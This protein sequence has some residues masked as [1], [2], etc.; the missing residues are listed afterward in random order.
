MRNKN[1]ICILLSCTLLLLCCQ[2]NNNNK[3]TLR[4]IKQ[5]LKVHDDNINGILLRTQNITL[6][7]NANF[8]Y[9]NYGLLDSMDVYNDTIASSTL[10]KSLKLQYLPNKIRAFVYDTSGR[11]ILDLYYDADRKIVKMVDTTLGNFGFFF[12]YN[13]NKISNIKIELDSIS[14][15][16]NFIY[17]GKNNLTQYVITDNQSQSLTRVNYEYD[18][19]NKITKELDIRFLS[20]GVR[21]LYAGGVNI[22]S[23]M[24]LNYGL[25][26]NNRIKSRQEFNLQTA[27]E[28]N[29]YL[30]DYTINNN[31]EITT[32]KIVVNDTIDVFY[33]YR[34]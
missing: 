9:N 28:G 5:S 4:K 2:P 18:L 16:A 32:R 14:H 30:F 15:F 19:D 8:H 11:F 17:D 12:T 31:Q 25:G 6:R 10:I 23:L 26:N 33:E 22:L 21:F 27:Q 29:K 24:N 34:Y 13:N 20:G 3:P 1:I 7:E